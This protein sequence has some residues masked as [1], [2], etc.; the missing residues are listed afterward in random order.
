M[1][2]P[3]N[4]LR[5]RCTMRNCMY[6]YQ[7]LEFACALGPIHDAFERGCALGCADRLCARLRALPPAQL[8]GRVHVVV[9]RVVCCGVHNP[10]NGI[11][12]QPP[13]TTSFAF[14]L[15]AAEGSAGGRTAIS[16]RHNLFSDFA[17]LCDLFI[18]HSSFA[19][20][21]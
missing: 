16:V 2:D 15:C 18:Q 3:H 1:G 14:A 13:C 8:C 17:L 20:K 7:S 9:C 12:A 19:L 4:S 11:A 5:W 21:H 6:R 10:K